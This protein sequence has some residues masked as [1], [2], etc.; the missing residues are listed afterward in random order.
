MDTKIK[1]RL[2]GFSEIIHRLHTIMVEEVNYSVSQEFLG[3]E[4]IVIETWDYDEILN[5]WPF[6]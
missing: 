4:F 3:A 6:F 1:R 2:R 5:H